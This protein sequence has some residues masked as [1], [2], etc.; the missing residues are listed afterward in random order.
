MFMPR[1]FV[2]YVCA[3]DAVRAEKVKVVVGEMLA[4]RRRE[5]GDRVEWG[6]WREGSWRRDVERR[7]ERW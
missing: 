1:C 6:V 4:W 5:K 2:R 3:E 7:G